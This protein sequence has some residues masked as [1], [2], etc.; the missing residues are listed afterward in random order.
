MLALRSPP[1]SSALVGVGVGGGC[2][3]KSLIFGG[4]TRGGPMRPRIVLLKSSLPVTVPPS[5]DLRSGELLPCGMLLK[6]TLEGIFDGLIGMPDLCADTD[7]PSMDVLLLA[8]DEGPMT[9]EDKGLRFNVAAGVFGL[10][11]GGPRRVPARLADGAVLTDAVFAAGGGLQ[12]VFAR[13]GAAREAG[14][15]A[16]AANS[17]RYLC[18]WT[19]NGRPYSSSQFSRIFRRSTSTFGSSLAMRFRIFSSRS[20]RVGSRFSPF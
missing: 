8:A 7:D 18:P 4:G 19:R 16:D 3:K 5:R 11:G 17:S 12:G 1:I 6:G 9:E 2:S 20:R 14:I 10:A 15:G 13:G